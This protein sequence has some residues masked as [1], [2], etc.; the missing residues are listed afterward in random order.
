M[1]RL[2]TVLMVVCPRLALAQL[3]LVPAEM[4]AT[5]FSGEGRRMPVVFRNVSAQTIEADLRIRLLQ[6]SS[7]TAI[8][9]GETPWKKLQVLPGQ[10][11]LETA[12]M[13]F[14]A[15]KAESRFLVQW[16]NA[17][18]QVLG[19]TEVMVYPTNLLAE[20]KA[21]AGETP[22][23]VLD[24]ANQLKPLL[25]ELKVEVEDLE[26]TELENFTGKLALFGPFAAKEQMPARLPR[27]IAARCKT[28]L[29][30]VWIQPPA[31]RLPKFQPSFYPVQLGQGTVVVAEARMVADLAENPVAQLNLVRLARLAMRPEPFAL[32]G[33]EPGE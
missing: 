30:A 24:P 1:K 10:K 32:P 13:A 27:R 6:A 33:L 12:R 2:V 25:K 19:V 7:S 3:E 17:N 29:A 11:V 8:P 14:P 31:G 15:V 5:A 9:L 18:Q 28:G 21:L 16:V 4:A 26:R 20:L 23:A 22:L